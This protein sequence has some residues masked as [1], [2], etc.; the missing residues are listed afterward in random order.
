MT[1]IEYYQNKIQQRVIHED[2]K[3]KEIILHFQRL[4]EELQKRVATPKIQQKLRQF[5]QT[6]PVPGIYLWG[7]V[8]IG[9]TL[10][11]DMFYECLTIPKKRLHFHL[12]MQRIHEKLT[13][14]QGQKNPLHKV[15]CQLRDEFSIICFDEFNVQD[16]ADAM[17]LKE[18]LTSFF[19]QGIV[20]ICTSNVSPDDLYKNGLQREQFLPA[21]DL[22][23]KQMHVLHLSSQHDYRIDYLIQAGTYFT[24]LN[25]QSEMNMEKM[26][27]RL[28]YHQF[29]STEPIE[30]FGR[31]IE[32][33]KRAEDVIWFDFMALC[34]IPRSQR[35]YI[36]LASQYRAVLISNVPVIKSDQLNL[37]VSW[38]N[39][40]DVFYDARM[41]VIIS[42]EAPAKDLYPKGKM[43]EMY[44]RTQSRLTEMQSAHYFEN[45]PRNKK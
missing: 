31:K 11:M 42:A 36:A 41:C 3:Q 2:E 5:F 26:F 6:K 45:S 19:E 25:Y 10:L 27:Q 23:K 30:L 1:P 37:I 39:A 34:G 33:R 8:G 40:I 32:I 15:V 14:M 22:I 44:S 29:I 9:K 13:Q 35:D 28:A 21:I 17:I 7:S 38:I 12:F 4:Y 24:P 20:M 16:I 18:L 43:S